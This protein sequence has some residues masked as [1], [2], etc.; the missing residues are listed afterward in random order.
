[1]LKVNFL[2]I[3]LL[4]VSAAFAFGSIDHEVAIIAAVPFD[5]TN[6]VQR[7]LINDTFV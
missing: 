1:M 4:A 7:G 2:A 5:L 3:L 6:N